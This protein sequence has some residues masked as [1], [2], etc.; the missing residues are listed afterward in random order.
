[1]ETA[2]KFRT[3][4]IVIIVLALAAF[5]IE[6]KDIRDRFTG[7]AV[8]ARDSVQDMQ[9]A[10]A[11]TQTNADGL[12]N[13]FGYTKVQIRKVNELKSRNSDDLAK[14]LLQAVREHNRGNQR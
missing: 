10:T 4:V 2:L 1:M 5:M 11:G 7:K 3:F 12:L 9:A 8:R 13:A 6:N 14:Y